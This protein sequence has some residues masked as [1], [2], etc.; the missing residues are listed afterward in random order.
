MY[1]SYRPEVKGWVLGCR[2][3]KPSAC[4]RFNHNQRL[5]NLRS[6]F[7]VFSLGFFRAAIKIIKKELP[8]KK[9]PRVKPRMNFFLPR[10]V[11]LWK[12]RWAFYFPIVSFHPTWPVAERNLDSTSFISRKVPNKKALP[13]TNLPRDGTESRGFWLSMKKLR[14]ESSSSK[15]WFV[16]QQNYVRIT[17]SVIWK[18]EQDDVTWRLLAQRYV[19][20]S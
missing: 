3:V 5:T 13:R 2:L 20:F 9:N 7:F 17:S 6:K 16:S 19:N 1:L 10:H 15:T 8:Q 4:S 18:E 14:H 11:G 12:I